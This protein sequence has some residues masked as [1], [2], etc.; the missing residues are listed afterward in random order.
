MKSNAPKTNDSTFNISYTDNKASSKE[1]RDHNIYEIEKRITSHQ[2]YM[3]IAFQT[4]GFFFLTTGAVLG[5]YLKHINNEYLIY[6]LLLPILLGTVLGGVFIYGASL[7]RESS[8]IIEKLRK[9]LVVDGIVV[10]NIPDVNLLHLLLR[11]FGYILLLVVL[12][13]ILMPCIISPVTSKHNY[14]FYIIAGFVTFIGVIS[15]HW[16]ACKQYKKLSEKEKSKKSPISY[17]IN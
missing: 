6:F 10:E 4:N 12:A 14:I 3:N 7:N 16:F 2:H 15:S 5:Y 17:F 8:F 11:I 9:S 13:L 1:K